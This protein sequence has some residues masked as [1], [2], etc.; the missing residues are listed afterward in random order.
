MCSC[1]SVFLSLF[2][3]SRGSAMQK[4]SSMARLVLSGQGS[5]RL[6]PGSENSSTP[7]RS[8]APVP[9]RL[10]VFW[11]QS[12][13]D[14]APSREKVPC[15]QSMQLPAFPPEYLPGVHR[16]ES[17]APRGNRYHGTTR[18]AIPCVILTPWR[19][20][21]RG[22][23]GL[24]E[25]RRARIKAC[26]SAGTHWLRLVARARRR[27]SV[28]GVVGPNYATSTATARKKPSRRRGC[29]PAELPKHL[30]MCLPAF[31][32]PSVKGWREPSY[33]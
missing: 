29:V 18:L 4:A 3:S 20:A 8:H 28:L 30:L 27:I 33:D 2:L 14:A 7:H 9:P 32:H 26:F 21:D 31:V 24:V 25:P 17:P 23:I 16:A 19:P 5:Q 11:P 12:V 22:T 1:L 13:H 10:N 15:L 6:A